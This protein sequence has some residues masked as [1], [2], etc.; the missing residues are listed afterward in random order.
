MV[1]SLLKTLLVMILLV[2]TAKANVVYYCSMTNY[3]GIAPSGAVKNYKL[4]RFTISVAD[5]G[6]ENI[7]RFAKGKGFN[8]NR[9]Y[10][11]SDDLYS[12]YS[13]YAA[14]SSYGEHIKFHN[15]RLSFSMNL[16]TTYV[17]KANCERF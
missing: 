10:T 1:K 7:L 3:V 2:S 14:D 13:W 4:S 8:A 16:E 5:E 6:S 15:G 9:V 12:D 11:I 17:M